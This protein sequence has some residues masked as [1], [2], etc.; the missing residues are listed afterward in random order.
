M[1]SKICFYF[2]SCRKSIP[3]DVKLYLNENGLQYSSR[4]FLSSHPSQWAD[5]LAP[6]NPTQGST[7]TLPVILYSP[8]G[9]PAIPLCFHPTTGYKILILST[10]VKQGKVHRILITRLQSH[11]K[12]HLKIPVFSLQCFHRNEWNHRG[13][14]FFNPSTQFYY[15]LGGKLKKKPSRCTVSETEI[16]KAQSPY[17]SLQSLG[18]I[19]IFQHSITRE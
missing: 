12:L 11:S 9:P 6:C 18:H 17:S 4:G 8:C 10:Q 7:R 15:P 5:L 13:V 16:Y 3:K 2:I 19:G 1:T 14:K